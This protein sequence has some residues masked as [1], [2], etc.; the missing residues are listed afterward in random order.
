LRVT[1]V[2]KAT[3]ADI[4]R[5]SEALGRAFWD[6]PVMRFLIPTGDKQLKTLMKNRTMAIADW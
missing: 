6:D 3:T 4:P 2:R 1:D 5:V